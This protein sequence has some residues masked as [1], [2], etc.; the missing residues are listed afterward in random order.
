MVMIRHYVLLKRENWVRLEHKTY[1]AD[2]ELGREKLLNIEI[3]YKQICASCRGCLLWLP[4]EITLWVVPP[5][6]AGVLHIT[7]TLPV[8][9]SDCNVNS[10][11]I[12]Q[13]TFDEN[14]LTRGNTYSIVQRLLDTVLVQQTVIGTRETIIRS[15]NV[16]NV[17]NTSLALFS[18]KLSVHCPSRY[19]WIPSYIGCFNPQILTFIG[20]SHHRD[21]KKGD[22][23]K[24]NPS[25]QSWLEFNCSPKLRKITNFLQTFIAVGGG[26]EGQEKKREIGEKKWRRRER[27]KAIRN[28][29]RQSRWK[30]MVGQRFREK[31]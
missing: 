22:F 19:L 25:L 5:P 9:Y 14:N 4:G 24:S 21:H 7:L 31:F 28:E 12:P 13:N 6:G 3:H 1:A 2:G 10:F 20:Y 29:E 8:N 23:I 26:R 11:S 18:Q 27:L 17:Q 16:N 15:N 30:K